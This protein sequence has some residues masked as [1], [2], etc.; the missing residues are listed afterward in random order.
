MKESLGEQCDLPKSI[1]VALGQTSV[2]SV[3]ATDDVERAPKGSYKRNYAAGF[4]GWVEEIAI[5]CDGTKPK[6]EYI[7]LAKSIVEAWKGPEFD[8]VDWNQGEKPEGFNIRYAGGAVLYTAGKKIGA[9]G[10]SNVGHKTKE[11]I[12]FQILKNPERDS[13]IVQIGKVK[14]HHARP[15]FIDREEKKI[16]KGSFGHPEYMNASIGNADDV[17]VDDLIIL[18]KEAYKARSELSDQMLNGKIIMNYILE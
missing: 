12:A 2:T 16:L 10:F 9:M 8:A 13:Q 18:F 3:V 7:D 5:R 6:Q 15:I 1:A 11:A 4:D 17:I 14:F